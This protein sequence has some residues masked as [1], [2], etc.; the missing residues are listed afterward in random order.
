M[1]GMLTAINCS[2][3]T[4]SHVVT[5]GSP[6]LRSVATTIFQVKSGIRILP[7]SL[8]VRAAPVNAG[9]VTMNSS[10]LPTRARSAMKISW[11]AQTP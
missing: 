5:F 3:D 9:P 6:V 7:S 2:R 8:M 1:L 10:L 4:S 11:L